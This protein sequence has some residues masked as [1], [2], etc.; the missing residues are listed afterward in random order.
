MKLREFKKNV[1]VIMGGMNGEII[2]LGKE[3]VGVE[4]LSKES[5]MFNIM[6]I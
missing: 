3:G 2:L 5:Y 4:S 1:E 6:I